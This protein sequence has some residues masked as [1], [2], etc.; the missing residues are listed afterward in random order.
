MSMELDDMILEAGAAGNDELVSHLEEVQAARRE[1][2][3]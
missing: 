3:E 1:S 2:K